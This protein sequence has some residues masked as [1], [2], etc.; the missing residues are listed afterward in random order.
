MLDLGI[1]TVCPWQCGVN[2]LAGET[3]ACGAGALPKVA[4]VSLHQWEE[5][6]FVG[7]HGAG[8][9]FFSYC[10]LHCVFCQNHEI[11]QAGVG[12]EIS[13]A[14]LAEIFLE[15]QNRG[16]QSLDLVSPTQYVPQ[17]I[18]ALDIAK[19]SGLCL[20][21]VYN[22]NGYENVQTLESLAGYVDVFLPDLKY[23]DIAAAQ[24][25]SQ[26]ADY[27][28]VASKAI[29]KMVELVGP[30][31]FDAQGMMKRGVLVRHLIIPG[32]MK[33]SKA[34][35]DWLWDTFGD[36]IYLSLMN[37]FTP[38]YEVSAYKEINRKLTTY[39]YDQVV[40]HALNLGIKQCFI[41]EGRTASVDF[42]PVF[43]GR[44]VLTADT[45]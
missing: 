29:Q 22:S 37:Q 17:I 40:D 31:V 2:R 24:K 8:T 43:N 7:E 20:P 28:S 42:V 45:E 36:R 32:Q 35:L 10:N 38:L 16:A 30:P 33:D 5:P 3:G 41:Q 27:F 19:A 13:I 26:A 4:L 6:C 25:Y 1:C 21:V 18:E 23:K 15:Q 44:G 9:V 34:L 39:E 11:S 12:E 14:R